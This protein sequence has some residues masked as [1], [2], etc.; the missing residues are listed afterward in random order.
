MKLT[1]LEDFKQKLAEIYGEK[2]SSIID[3]HFQSKKK[4]FRINTLV[5]SEDEVIPS[6]E[7]QG[8]D[9]QKVSFLNAFI[10][11]EVNVRLSDTDEFQSGKI[12]IQG[13]S[14]MIPVIFLD[15]QEGE[16][17]L[18]L[19]A[20]P[21]SKT[22]QIAAI[23]KN[24][25][26]IVAV[27]ENRNRFFKLKDNLKKYSVQNADVILNDAVRLP[28]LRSDFVENFDKVVVDAPCTSEA[29]LDLN[30]DKSLKSWR[31]NNASKIS[32]LQKGLLNSGL[33]MLKKGGTLIYSTC[34]YSVEENEL[35]LNWILKRYPELKIEKIEIPIENIE[36]GKVEWKGKELNSQIQN[37]VRILPD[38]NFN[39][40]FIA[41]IMKV[42]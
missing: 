24:K 9:I 10:V 42:N 15:I 31:R 41:K 14:S 17:I 4:T 23:G 28:F 18:D 16:S 29:E 20:A 2:S 37:S 1:K 32:K 22:T 7:R 33:K 11:D 6:L 5:S 8:F 27:E 12:Y 30:N 39:G 38:G 19:C 13:L 36:N 21:G 3:R 40:F 34:T 25:I 35:V 26:N